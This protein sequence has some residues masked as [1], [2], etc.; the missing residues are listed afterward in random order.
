[1]MHYSVH[2]SVLYVGFLSF[3]LL[4]IFV[5]MLMRAVSLSLS[6]FFFFGSDIFNAWVWLLSV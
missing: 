1:M 6:L 5:S 3:L 4:K 2:G